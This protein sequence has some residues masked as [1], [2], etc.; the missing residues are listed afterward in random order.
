MAQAL[1]FIQFVKLKN[2]KIDH[3]RA[4]HQVVAKSNWL[5]LAERENWM[6]YERQFREFI[7]LICKKTAEHL[8]A[9]IWHHTKDFADRSQLIPKFLIRQSRFC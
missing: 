2:G 8:I 5:K 7:A 4:R 6:F 9:L 1:L 3:K